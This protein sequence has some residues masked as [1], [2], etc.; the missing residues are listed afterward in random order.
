MV[1]VLQVIAT[2]SGYGLQLVIGQRLAK[3]L[4]GS[5]Q[6]IVEAIVRIVHLIHL[7]HG[8]Q[9]TFVKA[10]IMSDKG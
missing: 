4:A 7:E 3:L 1:M 8:L 6:G 9:T 2:G 10:S 5:C